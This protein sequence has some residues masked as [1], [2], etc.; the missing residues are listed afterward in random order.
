MTN[1]L[2]ERARRYATKAHAPSISAANT[3]GR[4]PPL[5]VNAAGGHLGAQ[6]GA[7]REVWQA[8]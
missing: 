1:T 2:A 6:Q 3:Q 4:A 5:H 8:K 7:S